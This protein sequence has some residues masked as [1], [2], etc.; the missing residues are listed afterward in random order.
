MLAAV[1]KSDYTV[2]LSCSHCLVGD[3][4]NRSFAVYVRHFAHKWDA[5]VRIS[6]HE[7]V[8]E[9]DFVTSSVEKMSKSSKYIFIDRSNVDKLTKLVIPALV[10]F[11]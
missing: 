10:R 4:W 5:S 3:R 11:H 8:L 2:R 7:K 6:F 1:V 9:R